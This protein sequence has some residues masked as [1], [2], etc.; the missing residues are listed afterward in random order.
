MKPF[1]MSHGPYGPQGPRYI[2]DLELHEMIA[3][4]T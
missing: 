1:A 4:D 3:R 2:V